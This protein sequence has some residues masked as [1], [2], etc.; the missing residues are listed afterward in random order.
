MQEEYGIENAQNITGFLGRALTAGI[1]IDA[2][3]DGNISKM[4][5]FG[6][7]QNVGFDAFNTFINLNYEA[8]G[9]EVGNLS[10]QEIMD[11]V[12]NYSENQQLKDPV[13]EGIIEDVLM[14]LAKAPSFVERVKD[15][16]ALKAQTTEFKSIEE[17]APNLL[18][19]QFKKIK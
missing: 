7:A 2:D 15:W 9:D 18:P 19:V 11:L 5:K 10:P 3:E 1:H 13:L 16:K 12:A 17:I 6:L 4:E 8:I 14:W